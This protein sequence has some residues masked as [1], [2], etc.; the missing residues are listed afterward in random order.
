M[1]GQAMARPFGVSWLTVAVVALFALV[2]ADYFVLRDSFWPSDAYRSAKLVTIAG[3][4]ICAILVVGAI[5]RSTRQHVS[6]VPIEGLSPSL[7]EP[8]VVA[9]LLAGIIW[10]AQDYSLPRVLHRFGSIP[11]AP[12]LGFTVANDTELGSG[13]LAF[14]GRYTDV[15]E[16]RVCIPHEVAASMIE[17][18]KRLSPDKTVMIPGAIRG[19]RSI[20]G[21][22]PTSYTFR[23][24]NP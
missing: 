19:E 1:W 15:G 9:L 11:Q 14:R 16:V 17:R 13:C 12:N 6:E 18:G 20:F 2:A 23:T 22:L 4:T 24:D 10:M 21:Y 7:V 8:V 3:I 5:W